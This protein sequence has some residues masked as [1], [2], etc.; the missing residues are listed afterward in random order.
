[1]TTDTLD[2]THTAAGI[3]RHWIDGDWRNSRRH[4]DSVNPATG[5]VIG[6]YALAG[7]DE[8]REATAAAHRAFRET[9]WKGDRTLRSR[10]LNEMDRQGPWFVELAQGGAACSHHFRMGEIGTIQ[11]PHGLGGWRLAPRGDQPSN[12]Q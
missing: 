1:M 12:D 8:A 4:E 6:R 7:E 5:E 3:A 11:G 10:V 9:N 2:N